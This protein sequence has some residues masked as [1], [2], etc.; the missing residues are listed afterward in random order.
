MEVNNEKE[1]DS[2]EKIEKQSNSKVI[3]LLWKK[4]NIKIFWF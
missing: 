2:I 1:P 4:V 3:N